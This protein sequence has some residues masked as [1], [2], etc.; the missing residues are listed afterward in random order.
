[1]T[2]MPKKKATTTSRTKANGGK[3]PQPQPIPRPGGTLNLVNT[4]TFSA[5]ME[6]LYF[7]N[8]G[9]S[10]SFDLNTLGGVLIGVIKEQLVV[11]GALDKMPDT[12][13]EKSLQPDEFDTRAA[14]GPIPR[15][16]AAQI[17]TERGQWNLIYIRSKKA[18]CIIGAV[19][20][21]SS[22]QDREDLGVEAYLFD[23]REGFV[24]IQK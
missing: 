21:E 19:D 11:V 20:I 10:A 18:L 12:G 2:T 9:G 8:N 13:A 23:L 14:G 4:I 17:S 24:N 7:I 5:D 3:Q 1:M 22:L 6:K 16:K 15:V